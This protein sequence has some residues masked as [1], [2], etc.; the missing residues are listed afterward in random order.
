MEPDPTPP[1]RPAFKLKP[2]TGFEMTNPPIPLG[3]KSADH[4]VYAWREQS[5]EMDRA[6][7]I[8]DLKPQAV[9]INRR[10]RDY[11]LLMI[12]G[13]S[14]FGVVALVGLNNPF[15]LAC[16]FAGMGLFSAGLTWLMWGVMG[17]Y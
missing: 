9:P 4:N 6:A 12:L 3:E 10:K 5:R 7:G 8:E 2:K 16:G 11:W 15:L 17:R 1:P 14:F 13:N